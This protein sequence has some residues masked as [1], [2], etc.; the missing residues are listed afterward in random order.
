MV[1]RNKNKRRGIQPCVEKHKI[2][3][4]GDS[5]YNGDPN[6]RKLLG[7][8]VARISRIAEACFTLI[9]RISC[10][11][12][13]LPMEYQAGELLMT[14]NWK[15]LGIHYA[16][17]AS[18]WVFA[19]V[20]LAILIPLL[21]E[22]AL[23]VNTFMNLVLLFPCMCAGTF[24]I[25]TIFKVT[26]TVQLVNSWNSTLECL[27]EPKGRLVSGFEDPALSVKVVGVA[28]TMVI[29]LPCVIV[30][31]FI[32]PDLPIGLHNIL[33]SF[34]IGNSM[35]RWMLQTCC[36]P[37]ECVFQMLPILNAGLGTCVLV[38]GI[39]TLKVYYEQLR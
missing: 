32:F 10:F 11:T 16:W 34:G 39:D 19:G 1:R 37:L 3:S 20:K 26:E 23:T 5:A 13:G 25:G 24:G 2:R 30:L 22:D 36:V 15:R 29:G 17:L 27:E 4:T 21:V 9:C 31:N 33:L 14:S 12:C 18:A 7:I 28:C 6:G 8:K 35:P 38:I